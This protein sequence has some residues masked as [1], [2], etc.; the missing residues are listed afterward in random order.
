L[1]DT[2]DQVKQQNIDFFNNVI[3]NRQN[4][5][6]QVAQ[7]AIS[8][9]KRFEK[10]LE[11]GDF[12]QTSILDV[13]CGTGGFYKFL[14]ERHIDC[15]YTGIDINANMIA[16]A[17]SNYPEI[18]N[19]LFVFDILE[20]NV[21]K[22]YEYV[23]SNGPLNL[24]YKGALNNTTTARLIER[25]YQIATIGFAITMT[26]A[27]TQ[28][29]DKRTFYYDPLGV[30]EAMFHFCRNVKFDHT[31]LPHDFCIFGYRKDLYDF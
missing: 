16:I 1:N 4:E 31:Y 28:K 23:I 11:M 18:Q 25:M 10:L 2:Y 24:K 21:S 27:L 12:N 29:P 8:H 3:A 5:H 15:A 20:E 6:N 9:L 22:R 14:K 30:L 7:S 26:S 13:G 17:K 19:N